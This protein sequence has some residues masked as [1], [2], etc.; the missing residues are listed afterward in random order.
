MALTKETINAAV[1]EALKGKGSRKFVQ[2]VDIAVNLQD[3]DFKKPENRINVE[4]TLPH[5]ASPLKVVVFAD[6]Q[7]ATEAKKVADLV[8]TST[9]IGAYA[10]DKKKMDTLAGFAV[11]AVPQ[12]MAQVGKSFGQFLS[13]KGR[14]PKPIL[15]NSNLNDLVQNTRNSVVLKTKGKLLP[16]LHCIVGKESMAAEQVTENIITVLDA[17]K[18]KIS[19]HQ[20]RDVCIKLTM[21]KAIRVR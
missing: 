9:D 13:A 12:L 19:E 20:I 6:G 15:P 21:G 5:P 3:V 17:L 14:L 11:L 18:K 4:I 1:E 2:S 16:T 8:I 7:V 10:S